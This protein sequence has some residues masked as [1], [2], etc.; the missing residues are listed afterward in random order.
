MRRSCP[1]GKQSVPAHQFQCRSGM[2]Q[3][4]GTATLN[5]LFKN[6]HDAGLIYTKKGEYPL[7][8][9]TPLGESVMLAKSEAMMAWPATKSAKDESPIKNG[10]DVEIEEI[11]FDPKLYA[12]LKDLRASIAKQQSVPAYVVFSNKTL[13]YFTRL[14]PTSME[15]GMR[16]KGVGEAKAAQYLERF[17][18]VIRDYK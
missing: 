3:E 5:E 8:T 14:R 12:A 10:L 2:L 17:I 4:A 15:A 16:I 6:M 13:E 1:R 18:E 9:L 11:G 7:V